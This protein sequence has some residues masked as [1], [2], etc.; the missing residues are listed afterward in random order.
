MEN[1]KGNKLLQRL[2]SEFNYPEKGAH[3]ISEKIINCQPEIKA[4]FNRWWQS[5]QLTSFAIEGY[6]VQRL[7]DEHGM[8]AIAAF[9]TLDWLLRE[10]E[11]ALAS[12]GRGHD[13]IVQE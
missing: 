2:I 10:P 13:K 1:F 6:T 3:L 8:N 12:L 9:L 4:A 11:A 7:Q 5:G